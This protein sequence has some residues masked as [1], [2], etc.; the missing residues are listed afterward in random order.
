MDAEQALN[1]LGLT[2]S[3]LPERLA[4][5]LWFKQAGDQITVEI[6]A[7]IRAVEDPVGE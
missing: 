1:E 5:Y 6:E 4:N 7:I 2:P 3:E